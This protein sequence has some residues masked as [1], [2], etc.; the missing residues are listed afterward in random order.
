MRRKLESRGNPAPLYAHSLVY[1]LR[2][3][4]PDFRRVA[5]LMPKWTPQKI[6]RCDIKGLGAERDPVTLARFTQF[7]GDWVR[8]H[9]QAPER[10]SSSQP[11]LPVVAPPQPLWMAEFPLYGRA[12]GETL[13]ITLSEC[14]ECNSQ[15]QGCCAP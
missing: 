6:F 5:H 14:E 15:S 9:M 7:C 1:S 11:T 8:R 12:C 2:R 13:G 10:V 4:D 3:A